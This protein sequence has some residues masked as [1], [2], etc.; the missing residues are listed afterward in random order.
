[1]QL[2]QSL[3]DGLL[4]G[5]VY[6]TIAA[7]LSL[8]FGV[9]RIVNWAH[10]EFLM[11]AMYVANVLVT[12]T[13]VDPYLSILI[14]GPVF[15]IVGYVLQ[16]GLFNRLLQREK[17][18]EPMSVM[19]FT[20]GLAMVLTNGALLLFS[21]NTRITPTIYQGKSIVLGEMMISIPRFISF[22]IALVITTGLYFFLMKTETGRA[23]RASSQDRSS[24]TLMGINEKKIYSI[25]FGIS[26]GLVGVS[27]SLLIPFFSVYP[28]V[29]LVFGFKAFVIVVMGGKGS[30]PGALLGGL[31]VGLTEK[32]GGLFFSDAYAQIILFLLFVV[33]LLCKPSGLLGKEKS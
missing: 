14:T 6:A 5:G 27:A 8:A 7:G 26:L 15:F 13:G 4:L 29:S 30:I 9:M 32:V 10:G 31:I 11:V 22:M 33:I 16:K 24:A 3:I 25:A 2:L 21:A 23:L 1:M 18:R 20:I 12:S 19:M 17:A 28:T